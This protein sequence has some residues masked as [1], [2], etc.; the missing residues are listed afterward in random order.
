MCR[1][2]IAYQMR[3]TR[4]ALIL[5]MALL[6][7]LASAQDEPPV[8][9]P[10]VAVVLLIPGS[11]GEAGDRLARVV[12]AHL[13]GLEV[14]L[15]VVE[16]EELPADREQQFEVARDHAEKYD[17]ALV[18]WLTPDAS[19]F[20]VLVPGSGS[21]PESLGVSADEP[22]SAMWCDVLAAMVHSMVAPFLPE[23]PLENTDEPEEEPPTESASAEATAGSST[24]I[25]EEPEPEPPPE[26]S[27]ASGEGGPP[28]PPEDRT[29]VALL[30]AAGYTPGLPDANGPVRHGAR[31]G[32][33]VGIG[34]YVE[35]GLGVDLLDRLPLE[36][37][38][39]QTAELF[40]IP[41]RLDVSAMAVLSG[42]QLGGGIG[43]VLEIRRVRDLTYDTSDAETGDPHAYFG[44]SAA[45]AARYWLVEWTALWVEIGADFFFKA[46]SYEL[47]YET[48]AR[49]GPVRPRG[50]VGLSFAFD[51]AGGGA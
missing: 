51:L 6:S 33:G 23:P 40:Q 45:A 9:E 31:L 10:P 8:E 41:I 20:H 26:S 30:A 4:S 47:E 49:F 17:A 34:R 3:T 19:G 38:D 46:S 15:G 18:F 39:D 14:D 11:A 32:L 25:D 7:P 1:S 28:P 37:A 43:A 13:S 35:L 48:R 12:E 29:R 24:S 5:T 2:V 44:L 22:G 21:E 16:I 36:A 50:V 42:F 27:E